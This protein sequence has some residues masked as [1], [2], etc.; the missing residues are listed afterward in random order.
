MDSL[1]SSFA[2]RHQ[3]HQPIDDSLTLTSFAHDYAPPTLNTAALSKISEAS[4]DSASMSDPLVVDSMSH[5]YEPMSHDEVFCEPRPCANTQPFGFHDNPLHDSF[6]FE[7]IDVTNSTGTDPHT[8]SDQG[9]KPRLS[10]SGVSEEV[11]PYFSV[12]VGFP[13]LM[14]TPHDNITTNTSL[15]NRY[16]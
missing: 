2:P 10:D 16:N 7:V 5:D 1:S 9:L 15:R 3:L 6:D 11:S 13:S 12:K 14:S 4:D 8:H